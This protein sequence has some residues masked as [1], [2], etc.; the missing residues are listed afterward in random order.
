M[1][2]TSNLAAVFNADA[3]TEL[4]AIY[5]AP[6]VSLLFVTRTENSGGTA[7]DANV[8]SFPGAS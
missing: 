6:A 7:D 4:R 2:V 3:P 8:S 1:S 5:V